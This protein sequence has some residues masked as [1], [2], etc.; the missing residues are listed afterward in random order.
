MAES[1]QEISTAFTPVH[2][3]NEGSILSG[4]HQRD[5]L[6]QLEVLFANAPLGILVL[7]RDLR[8]EIANDAL[9]HVLGLP[10]VDIGQ[11][12]DVALPNVAATIIPKAQ[13]VLDTMQRGVEFAFSSTMP[14]DP[15]TMRHWAAAIFAIGRPPAAISGVG[16]VIHDVTERTRAADR[17]AKQ[18]RHREALYALTA[19]LVEA[20]TAQEV[21]R[22]TVRHATAALDAVG[23]VVARRTEDG[24]IELLDAEGMP[25]DVA[26]EWRRFPV[27]APA[28]LAYVARTGE[29]LFLESSADWEHH[30]PELAALAQDVGHPANAVAPLII[31]GRPVGALGV[32]FATPRRFDAEE[33]ALVQT[34][35][36]Q[37]A[38]AR[39]RRQL[40]ESERAARAA[41][42]AASELKTKFMATMSHELR[43]PLQAIV[44][45]ADLLEMS[46]YGP[47]TESQQDA[48]SR[49]GRNLQHLLHLVGGVLSLLRAESGQIQYALADVSV[50]QALRFVA[51]ATAPQI[52]AK[53]LHT[54]HRGPRDLL[55][56]AD[57]EKLR[58][59]ILNLVSNAIKFTPEGGTI[60]TLCTADAERVRIQVHDTGRG[61][62]PEQLESVFEPFVQVGRS[63]SQPSEGSG[64]GLAI[65]REFARGMGGELSA[66]SVPGAGSTFTLVLPAVPISP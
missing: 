47:L 31:E 51:E 46:V 34:I 66:T 18:A 19:A 58:Q 25:P 8:V 36:R 53:R 54:E 38:L 29:P 27:S 13:E 52:A 55:V 39:E 64:L 42:V 15:A 57:G 63:L 56:R 48:L 21:V 17:D 14:N 49:I 41:A 37:C 5:R 60:T 44:G 24:H 35:A 33:R 50:D 23:T 9:A 12:V 30:F 10:R 22:A 3:G 65:S 26:A 2:G 43:T 7:N 61:I 28:P 1:N 62:A 45:Y 59:I 16:L 20:A 11:S 4:A 40:F 32:A 6:T